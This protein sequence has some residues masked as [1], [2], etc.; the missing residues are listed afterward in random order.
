LKKRISTDTKHF[1][2]DL[3]FYN[4]LAKCFV[5]IDLKADELSYQDIGQIDLYVRMF[6]EKYRVAGDNPTIGIILCTQKDNTMVKYS[7]MNE[8]KQLFASVYSLYMPTEQEIKTYIETKL[9]ISNL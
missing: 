2:I 6:D 1:F 3:V 5:V 4:Y 7:V 9:A 8:N